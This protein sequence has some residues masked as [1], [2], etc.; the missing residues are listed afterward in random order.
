MSKSKIDD[1]VKNV[2][3]KILSKKCSKSK[4]DLQDFLR[5]CDKDSLD[6]IKEFMFFLE[7]S[8]NYF[9]PTDVLAHI[10]SYELEKEHKRKNMFKKKK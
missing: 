4:C 9:E 10:L 5:H 3:E 6:I 2:F 1:T 7:V 8:D